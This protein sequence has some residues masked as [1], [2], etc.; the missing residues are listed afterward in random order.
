MAQPQ[1]PKVSP[2]RPLPEPKPGAHPTQSGE[3]VDWSSCQL[4]QRYGRHWDDFVERKSAS[5]AA[6]Q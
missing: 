5:Q 2:I 6:S 3:G 4:A 1:P